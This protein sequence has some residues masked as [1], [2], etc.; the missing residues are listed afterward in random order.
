MA[1]ECG[2]D[3]LLDNNCANCEGLRGFECRAANGEGFCEDGICN[4][5]SDISV[6]P[7]QSCANY[8]PTLC[9]NLGKLLDTSKAC[10]VSAK[11]SIVKMCNSINCC[12]SKGRWLRS[13]S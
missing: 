6:N 1:V 12:K 9:E 13:T 2:P 8:D 11:E 5:I 4:T 7:I 10:N 3:E